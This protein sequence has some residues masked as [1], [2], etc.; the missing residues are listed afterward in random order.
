MGAYQTDSV[1]RAF[2]PLKLCAVSIWRAGLKY[3]FWALLPV[4]T[5]SIVPYSSHWTELSIRVAGAC[6]RGWGLINI[7]VGVN[8]TRTSNFIGGT[9]TPEHNL[10]LPSKAHISI[11]GGLTAMGQA[12]A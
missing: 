8:R 11:H 9:K 4:G 2:A 7:V 10:V 5:A 12:A 1:T 3:V 6:L